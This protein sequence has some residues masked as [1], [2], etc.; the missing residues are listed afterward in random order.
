[1]QIKKYDGCIDIKEKLTAVVGELAA[2]PE[3][4]GKSKH[5]PGI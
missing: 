3:C 2:G 5:L 1:M 4:G